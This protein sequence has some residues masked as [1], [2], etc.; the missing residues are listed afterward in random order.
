MDP[1][2]PDCQKG[3]RQVPRGADSEMGISAQRFMRGFL[4]I[5][6]CLGEKQEVVQSRGRSDAVS[7]EALGDPTRSSESRLALQG[8]P[9][10]RYVGQVL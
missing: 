4:S 7:T 9:K 3:A 1:S 10:L 8:C 5:S 2:Y 6:A